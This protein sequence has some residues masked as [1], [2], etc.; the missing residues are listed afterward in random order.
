[1]ARDKPPV[2]AEPA[3]LGP[4]FPGQGF[5]DFALAAAR[6]VFVEDLES[7]QPKKWRN[8]CYFSIHH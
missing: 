1:M 2:P 8:N 4:A 5:F 7:Q 6:E 3:S